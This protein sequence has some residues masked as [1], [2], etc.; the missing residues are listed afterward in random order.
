MS[1]PILLVFAAVAGLA[2]LVIVRDIDPA[3]LL[4]GGLALS[5][6]SG[7]WRYMGL[8]PSGD[9]LLLMVGGVLLLYKEWR[10]NKLADLP[11]RPVHL[12]IVALSVYVLINA[13]WSDTVKGGEP[14]YALLDKFGLIPFLLFL[15]VPLAFR[16]RE[17]RNAFIVVFVGL[18]AYLGYTALCE[19]LSLKGLVFPRY[20][21]DP[22]I[23]ITVGRARGPFVSS[24]A[25]G[26]ALFACAVTCG[27]ALRTWTSRRARIFAALVGLAC[28]AGIVLTLTRQ[29]WL[30]CA[31]A[32]VVTM[33]VTPGLRRYLPAATVGTAIV[34]AAIFL[35][36]PGFSGRAHDRLNDQSPLWDRYN[37]DYAA[38]RMIDARPV[39]GF[40]WYRFGD[41]SIDY[42]RLGRYYPLQTV[43]RPHNVTL[44]NAAE[45]GVLATLVWLGLIL[46][47]TFRGGFGR[48]DP[49][50]ADWRPAVLAVALAWLV[51]SNFT[52]LSNASANYLLWFWLGLGAAA[53]MSPREAR[54]PLRSP[55]APPA[56][57]AT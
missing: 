52:P 33:L 57:P 49:E 11:L 26:L 14:T 23:G 22:N 35:L 8:P 21:V 28:L 31:V 3:W 15:V 13:A 1:D 54:S 50:M 42:L 27:L 24:D 48:G 34:V 2:F 5:V 37:S 45:L 25:D 55:L 51:T 7:A 56:L 38:L 4:A 16:T 46:Y 32:S 40:G 53:W 43:G 6:F 20:I 44:S 18:G 41:R 30:A 19:G 47:L 36:V 10:R 29:I 9:R 39:T 12:V 17:Q